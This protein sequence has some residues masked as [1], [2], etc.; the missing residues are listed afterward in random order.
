[1]P[2]ICLLS[3]IGLALRLGGFDREF[4]VECQKSGSSR[5]SY[6]GFSLAAVEGIRF[7]FKFVVYLIIFALGAN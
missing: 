1:M 6:G 7:G 2:W 3:A 4:F 5:A